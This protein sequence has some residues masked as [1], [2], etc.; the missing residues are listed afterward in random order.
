[1]KKIDYGALY[2][3]RKDGRYQKRMPDGKYLYDRDPEKLYEK[4][5]AYY[6]PKISTLSDVA[7]AWEREYRETVTERTWDNFAPHK[8]RIV[9]AHGDTPVTEVTASMILQDLQKAKARGYSHTVVN[10]I[11]V[12]YSGILNYAV[13][14]DYIPFN[15]ALS[16][17]L[18]KGLPKGK[19][20]APSE[21]DI[22][23]I[24]AHIDDEFG[25]FPFFLLCTG[26]RKGEALALEK[27]DID[28]TNKEI[29]VTKALTMSNYTSRPKIKEPKTESG[30]RT[31]P[32]IDI[33]IEP[34]KKQMQGKSPFLFPAKEY[35][36]HPGGGY[37]TETNY[38]T[39]WKNYCEGAGLIADGKPSVTAH[40][41]RHATASMLFECGVDVYT[42]QR[43]LGHANV[44]TTM[45][46]YTEIREKQAKKS[47]KKFNAGMSKI[48]SQ[49]TK[50]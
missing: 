38:D 37:M 22:K 39:A 36:G 50:R 21:D 41:L 17:K 14:H 3:L 49:Q 40:Q 29:S 2:T 20:S 35:H 23:K 24:I 47:I 46:I 44:T 11:K 1:M 31:V 48:M 9:E 25:F 30:N 16:V 12:I 33:L 15:P 7:E 4:E 27:K 19:R 28:F 32:I 42:A 43:I 10:S 5:M 18:P 13:A 34:L 6:A 8:K 45:E 26:L